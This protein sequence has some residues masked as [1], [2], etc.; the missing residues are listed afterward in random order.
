MQKASIDALKPG[1]H[2]DSIQLLCHRLLVQGFQELGIFYTPNS[3]GSGSWNSE[4]AILAS[5]VSAAFFP[6]GVGHSLGLDVHDVPSASK[7]GTNNTIGKKEDLIC[8]DFYKYL[9]L[10]LPLEAN[11]VVVS[12]F[13]CEAA[14]HAH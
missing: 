2:W 4:D 3:P 1:V 10:R 6:H 7:P 8:E 9:R 14:R 13:N 11:M 12:L 5:G